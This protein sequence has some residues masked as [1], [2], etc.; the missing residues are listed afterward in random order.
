MYFL[1]LATFNAV[2]EKATHVE[3]KVSCPE[4]ADGTIVYSSGPIPIAAYAE[5]MEAVV[6]CQETKSAMYMWNAIGKQ[7]FVIPFDCIDSINV[8]FI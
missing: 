5:V 3:L 1:N 4:T 7:L 6:T 8:R 2:R